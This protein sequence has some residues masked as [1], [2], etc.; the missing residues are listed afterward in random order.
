MSY[1]LKCRIRA[2]GDATRVDIYDDIGGVFGGGISAQD[3]TASLQGV[4]GA[5]DVHIN[6]SGGDV[7]DGLA[8]AEGIRNHRG[9]VTTVVDG[10]AASIASV[11]FQAGDR[12]VMAPGSML[13]IHDAWGACEGSSADM[14]AMAATLDKVSDNLAAAYARRAGGTAG[15]WRDA[16]R[17]ESWYDADEA[18]AAG[19]ADEVAGAAARLPAGLDVAALAAP[20]RIA[21]ALRSLPRSAMT[22]TGQGDSDG[23]GDVMPPCRMC[24][25]SGRLKHP[26]TGKNSIKCPGCNGTGTYDPD[27]DGDD[28]ESASGDTDH[29][30][31]TEDG[32]AVVQNAAGGDGIETCPLCGGTGKIREGHVTCPDCGGTGKVPVKDALN[33]RV[34]ALMR[35]VMRNADVDNTPWDA[36]RAWHNGTQA[37]DPAAF[38]AAI[39]AG[40]KTSGDPATQAHWALPYRY[41]PSSPP[42]AAAVRNC[43]ARLNQV[44]DLK[45]PAGTKRKLQALMKEINPDY[46][47]EDQAHTDFSVI[48]A[49][50]ARAVKE[51]FR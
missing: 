34:L 33:E 23:D 15:G 36:S 17:K 26:A 20:G 27:N 25:G 30:Y 3:F 22:A 32:H 48:G 11:I 40:E 51:A 12:R 44:Q 9:T 24:G 10:I 31:V 8:I 21:A 37:S 7:F 46:Q 42:N 39:C 18:V 41:T 6:S 28:D 19:L 29:D 4:R 13:M 2:A 5:L 35:Y 50:I 16:M 45:D 43:L 14:A 1:P 38:Y 47:P 49:E